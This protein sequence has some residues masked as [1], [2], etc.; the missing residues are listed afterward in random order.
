LK[1]TVTTN[2]N[3]VLPMD[4][5]GQVA[6]GN[7]WVVADYLHDGVYHNQLDAF[8]PV[9]V[10]AAVAPTVTNV[11]PNQGPKGGGSVVTITGTGFIGASAVA[12]GANAATNFTVVNATTIT[13]TAP[14]GAPGM[15]DVRV[16]TPAGQSAAVAADRFT[17]QN[18]PGV[19][20]VSPRSGAPAGGTMVTITGTDFTGATAV[21]FGTVAATAF[22]VNNATQITATAPAQ[23]AGTVVDITV[24]TP[25]GTSPTTPADRYT[26]AHA[27]AVT[28]ISP[29]QGLPAG[30]TVVIITGT[31]FT[32]VTAVRFGTMAATAF[33]VNSSTQITATAPA[34]ADGTVVDVRVITP[35]GTS[36]ASVT[37]HYTY[38]SGRPAVDGRAPARGTQFGGTTVTITGANFTG[39]TDVRFGTNAATF[40]TVD[41]PGKI[42]A[43][44]PPGVPG[45]VDILVTT[46]AGTSAAVAADQF[47]YQGFPTVT[48]INPNGGL[49]AGGNMVV[50]SGSNFVG[51][52][53]VRFGNV[54]AA[55]FVV[56]SPTQ[57]TATAPAEAVGSVVHLTVTTPT[58]TPPTTPAD[59]YTY[60][61]APAVTAINPRQGLPAGGNVVTIT[62][63]NFINVTNV[64]FGAV[65][66]TNFTVVNATQIMATAPRQAAGVVDIRVNA[67]AGTSPV[68]AADRYTYAPAPGV[69]AINPKQGLPTGGTA[70]VI[71]GTNFGGA[72]AVKF[73]NAAAARFNVDSP[74][75]ITAVAPPQAAGVVDITVTTLSGTSPVV[76]A[77]RYT[78]AP[79]PGVTAIN[80]NRGPT[81][82]GTA[83]RITGTNFTNVTG[84]KFGA[85][86]AA[87]FT[88][89]S[90]TQITA[91]APAQAGGAV[92]ITVT[93]P[94]GTSPAVAAD[95]FTYVAP[96][97]GLGALTPDPGL[98]SDGRGSTILRIP[99]SG[100]ESLPPFWNVGL[101]RHFTDAPHL[102]S[103]EPIDAVFGGADSGIPALAEIELQQPR[104]AEWP[105]QPFH[106][107]A[108]LGGRWWQVMNEVF[109]ALAA[110]TGKRLTDPA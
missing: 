93:T 33:T 10:V 70:V 4:N 11:T 35:S 57:I 104:L 87:N 101:D 51:V 62:G 48:F 31:D 79:A 18:L 89:D 5:L 46:P 83:V 52:T 25:A 106:G 56:N 8:T 76:A 20:A 7:Y 110:K 53:G 75:Q 72:T 97:T 22:T 68:V 90:A 74:T 63:T 100:I 50:I 58:G 19:T 42:T 37:D 81:T 85:V 24:T 84:V 102:T 88:V 14:A 55:A 54:A 3:G 38:R 65:A 34:Q 40:F 67:A 98:S 99:Q 36:P 1:D 108:E 107:A 64:Q 91:T 66:A 60:A 12:F 69:T 59:R 29:N 30:G 82:G 16:T 61:N 44:S 103:A 77:D 95:R 43:I 32:N 15:V 28:M 86:A 26:Y 27:P 71:M 41:N 80:P 49:P 21:R 73:G 2:A 94:S 45:I 17:Y 78:Y 13:A 96:T 23:A 92:D 109:P 39:A 9:R 6:A 105:G 47:T